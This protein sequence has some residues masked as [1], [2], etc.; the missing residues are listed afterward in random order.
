MEFRLSEGAGGP[1][2][3]CGRVLNLS[4][5][6]VWFRSEF[7]LPISQKIELAIPWPFSSETAGMELHINGRTIRADQNGCAVKIL[8]YSFRSGSKAVLKTSQA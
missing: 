7:P 8:R 5:S 6:G 3:G 1:K 4:T 2:T